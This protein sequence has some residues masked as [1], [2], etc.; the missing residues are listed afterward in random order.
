MRGKI[1]NF[2]ELVG[3]SPGFEKE[4][5]V[6]LELIEETLACIDTKKDDA[7]SYKK[8]WALPLHKRYAV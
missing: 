5:R 4:R 7:Q 8:A 6:V 3:N 1:R 2:N